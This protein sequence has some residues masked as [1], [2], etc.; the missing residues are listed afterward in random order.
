MAGQC[1]GEPLFVAGLVVG[2]LGV[3][4]AGGHP[5]R[6]AQPVG[7][8]GGRRVQHRL[9]ARTPAHSAGTEVGHEGPQA[10][11]ARMTGVHQVDAG[12]GG[13]TLG[14]GLG[15][16][17][18][19][20]S[21]RGSASLAGRQQ[22]DGHT[23]AYLGDHGPHGVLGIAQRRHHEGVVGYTERTL[24]ERPGLAAEHLVEHVDDL[25]HVFGLEK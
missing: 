19:Q 8:L 13:Q 24:G 23:G 9:L 20:G 14:E 10:H 6:E 3:G 22:I 18:G 7:D 15:Q 2:H 5:G 25:M 12:Q 16:R 21:G 4:H 11:H 17:A 1:D